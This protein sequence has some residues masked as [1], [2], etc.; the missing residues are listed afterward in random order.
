[1]L[2]TG[3][4]PLTPKLDNQGLIVYSESMDRIS[5]SKTEDVACLRK[6]AAR[7]IWRW[8]TAPGIS[9][10]L[11]NTVHDTLEW[12]GRQTMQGVVT[13]QRA[14]LQHF[15]Q[16]FVR[17][18]N[19]EDPT[20][21]YSTA[22][23]LQQQSR[24]AVMLLAIRH[25]L[26]TANL[27]FLHVEEKFEI[28]LSHTLLFTGKI[29]AVVRD[30]LGRQYIL[31]YKTAVRPWR[32]DEEH[33]KPQ[34]TAYL[35]AEQLLGRPPSDGVIFV[36]ATPTETGYDVDARTTTRTPEQLET[37]RRFCF[38]T[39]DHWQTAAKENA[40]PPKPIRL[41]SWCGYLGYCEEG[42]QF[43][44]QRGFKPEVPLITPVV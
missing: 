43:L 1:M 40:Y 12:H 9:L 22:E 34:A 25:W 23:R 3:I 21:L 15:N 30:A 4:G 17:M 13:E 5:H 37:Y 38:A 14:L 16:T 6:F 8:P 7:H 44:R 36:V 10:I 31:D 32:K 39:R 33:K 27:T 35:L 29:D 28:E 42:Q 20:K 2:V 11:G 26:N 41:C 19:V 24:G 18:I